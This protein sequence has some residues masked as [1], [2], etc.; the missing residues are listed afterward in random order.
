MNVLVG[1]ER[2]VYRALAAVLVGAAARPDRIV[3][4]TDRTLSR[5]SHLL[6]IVFRLALLA[7]DWGTVFFV[8]NDGLFD[9]FTRLSRPMQVRYARFWMNHPSAIV[10]QLFI[11]FKM[12]VFSSHYDTRSEAARVGYAPEWLS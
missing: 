5:G 4:E 7:F 12:M 1:R 11:W 10:R 6:R 9:L 3:E 2:H 8:T